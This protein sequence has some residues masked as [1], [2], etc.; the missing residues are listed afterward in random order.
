MFVS[1][2]QLSLL[3][4]MLEMC[5]VMLRSVGHEADARVLQQQL[6]SLVTEQQAAQQFI[7]DNPPPEVSTQQKQ[8]QHHTQNATAKQAAT[9]I[10]DW[11]WDILRPVMLP[12][13]P[14]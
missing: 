8:Q 5:L 9:G 4:R 14:G 10:V 7:T 2:V 12:P 6:S 13:P 1:F 3:F 11:K